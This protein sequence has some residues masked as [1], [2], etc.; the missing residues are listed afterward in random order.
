MAADA[1]PP[2]RRVA[3]LSTQAQI[4][5]LREEGV[6]LCD[7]LVATGVLTREAVQ[8]QVHRR[9][10][11]KMRREH[12]WCSDG[13]ACLAYALA[14]RELALAVAGSSDRRSL[15]ALCVTSRSIGA[16]AQL[17]LPAVDPQS[18]DN[19]FVCGGYDGSRALKLVDRYDPALGA[20]RPMPP[21]ISVREAS[22]AAIVGSHLYVVGGFDGSTRL[23][24]AERLD[25]RAGTWQ[26]LPSMTVRRVC[27]TATSFAGK[28]FVCA[29]F[30]GSMYLS[31]VEAFDPIRN[32]WDVLPP[33]SV[34]REGCASAVLNEHLYVCG[35][36]DG[37]QTLDV[38]E[39]IAA[40]RSFDAMPATWETMPPMIARR[41]GAAAAAMRGRLYVCGGFDGEQSLSSRSAERFDPGT[42]SWR[43]LRDMISR[44]AGAA[45]AVVAGQLYV[46]GGYDGAQHL[47]E[48]ER[49]DPV[50]GMWVL[51]PPMPTRRG[52]AAGAAV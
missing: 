26:T 8:A 47:S 36:N 34:A 15:Q 14:A 10:F 52:Y 43:A 22:A 40:N 38:V 50:V 48:C 16:A 33:L 35:G 9:R 32:A 31:S 25:L 1:R 2:A 45:A 41:D 23:N 29:G 5:T 24:E 12:P 28:L 7:C 44:R 13:T 6:A 51:L 30:D 3:Q 49:L 4:D 27:A 42:E 17:V 20:W 19:V 39:R 37:A 18:S 11:E 46:C 21:M